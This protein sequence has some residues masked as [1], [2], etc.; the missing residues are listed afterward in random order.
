[1]YFC[2]RYSDTNY[3]CPIESG[4]GHC[5]V[6]KYIYLRSTG[7]FDHTY[8]IDIQTKP[9][10]LYC[11]DF[12]FYLKNTVNDSSIS[13]GWNAK[14]AKQMIIE[15][16]SH[17]DNRWQRSRSTYKSASSELYQIWF[18]IKRTKG[19]VALFHAVD[20]IKI[21]E[22]S[23]GILFFLN[24]LPVI[25]FE[26]SNRLDFGNKSLETGEDTSISTKTLTLAITST[27]KNYQS[28]IIT[29]TNNQTTISNTLTDITIFSTENTIS[30][31]T[32]ALDTLIPIFSCDSS[33][34]LCF[35]DAELIITNGA[36]FTSS[37]LSQQPRASLSDAASVIKP[38]ANN[39]T[40][41][42]P[43]QLSTDNSTNKSSW[44]MWFCYNNTCLTDN[45]NFSTCAL[46]NYGLISIESGE[47]NKTISSVISEN[48]IT[49]D[50]VGGEQC[51]LYYYYIT[52]D[53]DID[54]GQQLSVS[55]RSDNTSD[56]EIE[57]DRLSIVDMKENRWNQRNVTFN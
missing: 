28:T 5:I 6:G 33:D 16:T 56:S 39:H 10:T 37:D 36:Q 49:R 8:M 46:G 51:L 3:T 24:P 29:Q 48:M 50:F 18:K 15:V 21:F 43:Y 54:Y 14:T 22:G 45:E 26:I 19:S 55:I 35:Q 20:E 25:Y 31:I 30:N 41:K 23:C 52:L 7:I 40:C 47:T 9:A 53:D 12:D 2:H 57:I 17:I 27:V 4:I 32:S 38:T 34:H 11:L 42:L 44:D 13:F 1:M